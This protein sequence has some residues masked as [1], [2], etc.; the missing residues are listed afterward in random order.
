[1]K[2]Q[3]ITKVSGFHPQG[4]MNVC[5]QFHGSLSKCSWN[6]SVWLLADRDRWTDWHCHGAMQLAWLKKVCYVTTLKKNYSNSVLS[7]YLYMETFSMRSVVSVSVMMMPF[8][9]TVNVT[10][11]NFLA[12]A[13][14]CGYEKHKSTSDTEKS[15][16][17]YSES[18]TLINIR[19]SYLW[20]N[21][22][23]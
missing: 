12:L 8:G 21:K 14:A 3:G 1:M 16:H 6:V 17:R 22:S 4:T 19:W 10:F 11:R 2:S 9:E 20:L 18:L 5:I 13:L 15:C 23:P 7:I